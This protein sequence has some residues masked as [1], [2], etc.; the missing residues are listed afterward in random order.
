MS[1]DPDLVASLD[2]DGLELISDAKEALQGKIERAYWCLNLLLLDGF[3]RD[4]LERL[5]GEVEAFK[6][7][8]AAWRRSRA[9]R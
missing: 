5:V 6:R 3:S 2:L 4:D 1:T 7:A 8:C 9:A